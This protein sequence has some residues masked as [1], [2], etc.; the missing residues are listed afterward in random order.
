[1]GSRLS[2]V[3]LSTTNANQFGHWRKTRININSRP[4]TNVIR[5]ANPSISVGGLCVSAG[6]KASAW[7]GVMWLL[8]LALPLLLTTTGNSYRDAGF[9]DK[10]TCFTCASSKSNLMCN[11]L[12]IDRPCPASQQLC[13]TEHKMS[14]TNVTLLVKKVCSSWYE[15]QQSVGCVTDAHQKVC[16]A[17]CSSSYCN[18]DLPWSES[19][20]PPSPSAAG[21]LLLPSAIFVSAISTLSFSL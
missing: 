8:A 1:M 3:H 18:L 9:P 13:R 2:T 11:R 16:T 12:A 19:S 15:C 10:K 5:S 14:I 21:S 20:L 4:Q 17:C 6:E 7:Y